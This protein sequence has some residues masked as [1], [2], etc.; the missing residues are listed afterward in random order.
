VT[1]N[2]SRDPRCSE[3]R[4]DADTKRAADG[5]QR[6]KCGLESAPLSL[7]TVPEGCLWERRGE[8]TEGLEIFD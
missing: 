3:I 4:S 6:N 2:V 8:L 1:R 5:D 7:Q